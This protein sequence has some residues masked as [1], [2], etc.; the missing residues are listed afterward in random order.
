MTE[1]QCFKCSSVKPLNEFYK[2][3]RMADGHLNKCKECNKTDVRDNR[4][5]KI[6]YYR[7]YDR[8]RGNRLPDGYQ[9]EYAQRYPNKAKA[10]VLVAYHAR[11][12]NLAKQPCEQC[13]TKRS[14]HAHHDDYAKPLNVRW[15]CAAHHRQWH[16]E[17]GEGKNG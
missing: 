15:L 3:P 11:K 7:K 8:E 13:G 9:K 12:G 16:M 1:K 5:S 6:K 4:K 17:N 2:H 14:V 10:R